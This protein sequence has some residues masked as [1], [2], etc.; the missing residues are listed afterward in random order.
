LGILHKTRD[1]WTKRGWEIT[2]QTMPLLLNEIDQKMAKP[3]KP[4]AATVLSTSQVRPP[5]KTEEVEL[6]QEQKHTARRLYSHLPGDKA[7]AA[8]AKA[9]G[10][11]K[12]Q[13]MAR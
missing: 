1:E 8:Y 9:Y 5:A 2:P 13:G 12:T 11:L 10:L 7:E 4:Q 6:N 3:A